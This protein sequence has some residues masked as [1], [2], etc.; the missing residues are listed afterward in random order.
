[1]SVQKVLL[2][3]V[4]VAA[5]AACATTSGRRVSSDDL[6]KIEKGQSTYSQVVDLL[7][8]PETTKTTG[9]G[10]VLVYGYSKAKA[11]ATSYIPYVGSLFGKT[12]TENQ[13]VYIFLDNDQ[14]VREVQVEQGA[15]ES[16]STL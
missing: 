2:G 16:G 11:D 6:Q 12:K 10:Q 7:G 13:V 1:M 15:S 9:E 14:V 3:F 4:A 5:L 8:E